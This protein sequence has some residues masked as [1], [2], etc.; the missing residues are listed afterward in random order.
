MP[1]VIRGHTNAPAIVIGEVAADLILGR[2][3]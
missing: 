2:R 3:V 1:A